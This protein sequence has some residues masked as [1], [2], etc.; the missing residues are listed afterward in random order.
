MWKCFSHILLN[1][2]MLHYEYSSEMAVEVM[3]II[4]G[5]KDRFVSL[6]RLEVIYSF[7]LPSALPL[8]PSDAKTLLSSGRCSFNPRVKGNCHLLMSPNLLYH[9]DL[10]RG[11]T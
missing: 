8:L 11:G 2:D 3:L 6:M 7:L 1:Q 10:A 4:M 5:I 9:S